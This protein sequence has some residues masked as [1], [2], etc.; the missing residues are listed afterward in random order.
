MSN[1]PKLLII[2]DE[3]VVLDSCN[4]I[5]A[6]AGYEVTTA[7]DGDQGLKRA[8]DLCPD[9]VFVDLKM[10]G[11]SGFEVLRKIH[12]FDP[13]IV[14]IVITGYATIGSAVE[15]MKVGA[16]DFVPKPFTPEEFRLITQRGLEKRRLVLETLALRREKEMLRQHFAAIV[17]HE[18]KSPLSAVQ[19][20]LFGLA[21]E[22]SDKLTDAQRTR[23]ER[24]KLRVADLLQLINTW[25]RVISVDIGN[26]KESFG[27]I[28]IEDV[29]QKSLECV[30][31]E[32]IRKEID[33]AISVG[34]HLQTINGNDGSLTEVLVNLL[35]N[36]VKYSRPGG[37][38]VVHAG[39]EADSVVVSVTD[40]GIGIPAED[41]PFIFQ[42][43]Y[44]GKTER[45][46]EAGCGLG[47]AISR[48]IVD[49]HEGTITVN[50]E[51]GR[52]SA[53]VVSLPAI[54]SEMRNL[55]R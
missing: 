31:P 30:Q 46:T 27:P 42:G 21:M 10:P 1:Q 44:R 2:D 37:S 36:A 51:P 53:F 11:I 55:S 18:L 5:L 6:A 4:E 17:S 45:E 9:L 12:A 26:L 15:A 20:N 8:V 43:F 39:N 24:M 52:G 29:I 38:V 40:T 34:E 49:A 41:L 3:E 33:I 32:A 47:L 28:S 22:L 50:S 54:Q 19:Q 35:S 48:R 7:T 25:L 16:Y 14:T 13:T 23:L